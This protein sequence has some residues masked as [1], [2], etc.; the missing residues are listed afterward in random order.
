MQE[1]F[2]KGL[3]KFHAEKLNRNN[4]K[5]CLENLTFIFCCHANAQ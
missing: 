5:D 4:L 3:A 1:K 2:K